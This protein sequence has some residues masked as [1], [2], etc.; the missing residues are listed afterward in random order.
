MSVACC[1]SK[2]HILLLTVLIRIKT[3]IA[4]PSGRPS[5]LRRGSV[6]DRLLGLRVRIPPGAW[7]F[8]LC[9]LHSKDKRHSQDN[10]D[11]AVIQMKYKEQKKFLRGHGCLC[12]VL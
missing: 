12:C 6:A 8:V 7:I 4:D 2:L 11:K 5:G 1:P 9:E 3:F 10:Q